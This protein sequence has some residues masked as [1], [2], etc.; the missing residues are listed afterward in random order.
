MSKQTIASL[1]KIVD[2]LTERV[3]YLEGLHPVVCSQDQLV[4]LFQTI[5]FTKKV[6]DETLEATQL[7][8]LSNNWYIS[9]ERE[10]YLANEDRMKK[11]FNALIA[12]A[13]EQKRFNK[14]VRCSHTHVAQLVISK[15]SRQEQDEDTTF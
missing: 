14:M 13:K 7:T 6:S 3:E 4:E 2:A 8:V 1:T 5:G 9:I 10:Y 15:K 12:T 11:F